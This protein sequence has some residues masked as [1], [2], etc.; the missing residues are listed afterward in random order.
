MKEVSFGFFV[1][2]CLSSLSPPFKKIQFSPRSAAEIEPSVTLMFIQCRNVRSLA[3]KA[4]AS[5][6]RS[7]AMT[8]LGFVQGTKR[9][10]GRASSTA[11]NLMGKPFFS[12]CRNEKKAFLFASLEDLE[13]TPFVGTQR[14]KGGTRSS[15]HGVE[16]RKREIVERGIKEH[17]N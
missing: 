7:V 15:E 4:L 13:K 3:K 11:S 16:E 2:L 14:V 5:V 17:W 10:G 8:E 12:S 9:G 6:R 1:S